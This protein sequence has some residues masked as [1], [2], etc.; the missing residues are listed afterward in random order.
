MGRIRA[1]ANISF[2]REALLPSLSL[3][4]TINSQHSKHMAASAVMNG[5]VRL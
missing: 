4:I 2:M 1:M 5:L 3:L